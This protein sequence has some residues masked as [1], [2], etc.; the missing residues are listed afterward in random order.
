MYGDRIGESGYRVVGDT[1]QIR[2][3]IWVST[4]EMLL[5]KPILGLGLNGFAST[6][7]D[8]RLIDYPEPFQYPHNFLLTL[9]T[10]L[11]L[12]GFVIFL[13]IFYKAFKL[14]YLSF[15]HKKSLLAVGLISG[16]SYMIIHGFV[17]VPYFK[18]DLSFMFWLLLAITQLEFEKS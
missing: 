17:D 4:V 2:Y 12:F 8:Y 16:I 10:E 7:L 11:G 6:Y 9:W 15:S 13:L 5:E 18:N 1:L 3:A 14:N